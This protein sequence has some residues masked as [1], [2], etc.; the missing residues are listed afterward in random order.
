MAEKILYYDCFAGISGDMN[1]AAMIDLGVPEDHLR[2]QLALLGVEGFRLNVRRESRKGISGTRVDVEVESA[3]EGRGHAHTSFADIRALIE[4]S[5]LPD[6]VKA[7]SIG[8]FSL[9]AEAEGR[10]HSQPA[11]EVH[12]HEVG[13]VDSIVDIVGAAICLEY[14]NPDLIMASSVELGGG[15][16]KSQHGMLP[17]PAPATAYLL[18]G[19]PVTSAATQ[20][21]MTTPTG[22]AIL[23]AC[24]GF[25]TDDKKF[26]IRDVGYG[27]GHRDTE[28]P[29]LLRVFLG[30]A[31]AARGE[32]TIPASL[33]ECNLDD[34]SPEIA[35]YLM[36]RLFAAGASDVYFTPITMK[37]SRP[38]LML[39]VLCDPQTEPRLVQ[40]IVRETTTFG[41]RR[42]A[43]EK[44]ALH[45]EERAVTTSLG[46]VRVK[47]GFL[48]GRAVKSKPEYEDCRRIAEE[49]GM[50]L[51]E[52]YR[53]LAREIEESHGQEDS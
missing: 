31:A 14:L 37:K 26:V 16:V 1:L 40:L 53:R 39:S 38:A 25:F 18:R 44:T 46:S 28:V 33:L 17:V 10:V 15:F 6:A 9:L 27:V 23:S 43:L 49:R 11:E 13:A 20:L 5:R 41:L 30:E 29:N 8:I 24:V 19:K 36:E 52:V 7:R 22:A 34:M 48:N 42:I 50:P 47:T 21:E 4:R 45:R 3:G 35:A 2:G 32:G 12:F 51:Q